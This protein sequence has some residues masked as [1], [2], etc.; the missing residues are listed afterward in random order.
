MEDRRSGHSMDF[1]SLTSSWKLSPADP[2]VCGAE[3]EVHSLSLFPTVFPSSSSYS[4]TKSQRRDCLL[5][6]I[7]SPAST[8]LVCTSPYRYPECAR[9]CLLLDLYFRVK[10]HV[11]KS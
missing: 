11:T 3:T 4:P 8:L 1:G 5:V 6:S 10:L 9:C 2:R 7:Y